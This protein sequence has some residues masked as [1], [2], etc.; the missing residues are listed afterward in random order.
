MDSTTP[1]T[2]LGRGHPAGSLRAR[3]A[4][5]MRGRG[6]LVLVTGEAGIGKTT[7][8]TRAAEEARQHGS[9]VLTGW[10]SDGD[11]TPGYWPWVQVLRG[12]RRAVGDDE[13]A[14]LRQ[15]GGA[16]LGALLG[17]GIGSETVEPFALYDAVTNALISAAER[18]PLIVILD[19]LHWADAASLRLLEFAM[20]QSWL[21]PLLLMGTYRDV[22][23]EATPHPLQSLLGALSAKATMIT[24]TG[25][26]RTEVGALMARTAGREPEPELVDTVFRRTGGNPFFVEQTAR[27]WCS[28]GSVTTVA[29]QVTDAVRARLSLL[30]PP[31]THLLTA[32]AVLGRRFHRQL[33]AGAAG[34]PAAEVDRLLDQAVLAR[35]VV[36][37]G[38]GEFA[39]THDL[40]REA[41]HDALPPAELRRMHAEVVKALDRPGDDDRA[42]AAELA[43]HA[44]LAGDAF[45]RSRTL[46]L[47]LAAARQAGTWLAT[48]EAV[49]HYRRALELVDGGDE[50]RWAVV[51]LDLAQELHRLGER[52]EAWDIFRQVAAAARGGQDLELLART[53]LVLHGIG[54]QS[55]DQPSLTL[56]LLTEAHAGL[57][58]GA[59]PLADASP[60]QLARQLTDRLTV[61]A[62]RE[63]DDEALAFGLWAWHDAIWGLGSAPERLSLIDEL[64]TVARRRRDRELEYFAASLRWV[65]WLE[66]GDPGYLDHYR[67]FV[68]MAE[69]EPLAR[70]TNASY[71]DRSIVSTH[72]GRF[73]EAEAFLD[74]ALRSAEA[75]VNLD[76]P[77]VGEH[78]RWSLWLLQGQFG[79]LDALHDSL[80]RKGHPYPD[81]LQAVSAVQ[82]GDPGPAL[83]YLARTEGEEHNVPR[84]AEPLRLRLLAHAA[85]LSQDPLL[86][87]QARAALAPFPGQW[88]VSLYGS[89]I[90]GPVHLWLGM[91]HAAQQRWSAAVDMLTSAYRS[92]DRLQARPWSIMARAQLGQ[93]LLGRGD[94][95]DVAAARRLL[96]EVAADAAAIGMRHVVHQ[97][98]QHEQRVPA[99]PAGE[100]RRHGSVWKLRFDGRTVQLNDAK[101]L[102]DLHYLISR[103][104]V[105]V[106]AVQL[107]SPDGGEVV[108]AARSLGGDPVLDETAKAQYKRRLSQLEEQIEHALERHDDRRAAQ[109]DEERETL[110]RHLQDAAALGGRSRRLGSEVERARKAV[111]ARIHDVLRKLDSRH[112]ALAAHLRSTVST[113]T[114]CRYLT[115]NEVRWQL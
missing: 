11:S 73:D 41:L 51:R 103:P 21:Q 100:F 108:L 88:L 31:V 97:A 4:G 107:L 14:T 96:D 106:P 71:I 25:L 65:A 56:D 48:E 81:L 19:D 20:R 114:T 112:P 75:D 90:S 26:D 30:P 28:V 54:M 58:D 92:A 74:R 62:R 69:R 77:Y 91:V 46:E 7:L 63:E 47:L 95:S 6:G 36:A 23:V 12:L 98:Q 39:F 57:A 111:T 45:D 70:Y 101:G 35:L 9:L 44:Y 78:L 29:P 55:G 109:L 15:A 61:L 42:R 10:C 13:W 82:Q 16:S 22:E 2:L 34:M 24:L 64:V 38:A 85:A 105:D 86:C 76:V 83:R 18:R 102:R 17:E 93:A 72:T 50:C 80:R 3:I 52:E 1:P 43:R 59:E 110:L 67:A 94:P 113:G 33:L 60:D 68:A 8:V 115:D 89:D 40:V 79:Q 32:A 104:G 66:Q 53:A 37:Q 5:A 99:R 87:E 27:L 49:G 84:T